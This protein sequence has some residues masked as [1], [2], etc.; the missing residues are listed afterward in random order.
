MQIDKRINTYYLH[1]LPNGFPLPN[2]LPLPPN[3]FLPL[4]NDGPQPIGANKQW[5]FH[6]PAPLHP[7]G[8]PILKQD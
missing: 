5:R 1:F 3:G 8:H 7:D 4:P 6:K 2:G